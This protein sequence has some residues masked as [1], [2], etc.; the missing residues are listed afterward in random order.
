VGWQA[1]ARL[2]LER[3]ETEERLRE[4]ERRIVGYENSLSWRI[5]RPL[6][7]LGASRRR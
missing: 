4:L 1:G 5:T 2:R 3:E 6:R 7:N